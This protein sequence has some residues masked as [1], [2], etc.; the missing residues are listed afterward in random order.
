MYD[1]DDNTISIT[2]GDSAAFSV[3]IE[4]DGSTMTIADTDDV[5][6]VMKNGNETLFKRKVNGSVLYLM[7]SDTSGLAYG[8]YTY[9][10]TLNG[11]AA[12]K[13]AKINVESE[14]TF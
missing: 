4:S 14:V 12:I 1:V 2:R 13:N 9:D 6:F 5:E 10:L 8:S 7:P 11:T 3:I